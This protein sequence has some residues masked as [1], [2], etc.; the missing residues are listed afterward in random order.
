L[1][2]ER[3]QRL[4]LF[5]PTGLDRGRSR[6]IEAAWYLT[7]MVFFLTAFPW[8]ARLKAALLR[9]FG[10]QVGTGLVMRPR[11]NIHFPWKLTLGDHVWIGEGCTI[12][13][14]EPISIADHSALAHEVY[15]A[16]G[17]HDIGDP[18]LSYRNRPIVIETGCWVATRAMIGPGVT[19]G[20]NSVVGAGA[21][22]MKSVPPNSVMGSAVSKRLSDR[23]IREAE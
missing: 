16:A 19:I 20:E 5:R 2:T 15:L 8:P 10:A 7:K 23:V 21:I 4:D 6:R 18:T 14:L 22:V 17:G 12:L 1:V 3:R 13:N 9:L 11:V